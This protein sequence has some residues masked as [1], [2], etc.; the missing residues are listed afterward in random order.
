ML[1]EGLASV[2]P[3]GMPADDAKGAPGGAIA[4]GS[5]RPL[6]TFA[7]LVDQSDEDAVLLASFRVR[8]KPAIAF[9]LGTMKPS[10]INILENAGWACIPLR[11]ARDIPEA[12]ERVQRE[13]G[14]IGVS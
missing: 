5:S 9:V 7:M 12:W 1:L 6:P 10:A 14:G 2:V 4:R 8:A 3:A 13:R 11:T